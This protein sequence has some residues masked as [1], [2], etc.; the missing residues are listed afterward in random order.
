M[1]QPLVA[2]VKPPKPSRAPVQAVTELA[3]EAITEGLTPAKPDV[4]ASH[5]VEGDDI[6]FAVAQQPEL[7]GVAAMAERISPD[8][9]PRDLS[10]TSSVAVF[11][12]DVSTEVEISS[13]TS[14]PKQLVLTT[15]QI[16]A[17]Q[18]EMTEEGLVSEAGILVQPAEVTTDMGVAP[19]VKLPQASRVSMQ[20]FE[21]QPD[22]ISE[23]ILGSDRA[24]DG[25]GRNPVRNSPCAGS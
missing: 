23:G 6:G 17:G 16:P 22:I 5:D 21:A 7:S 25:P 18:L 24:D 13:A 2:T 9:E 10:P 11:P 4:A 1:F 15:T 14:Q 8:V 12:L 20:R 3:P 19:S